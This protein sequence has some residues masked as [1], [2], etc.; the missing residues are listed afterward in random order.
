MPKKRWHFYWHISR[1]SLSMLWLLS[2]VAVILVTI[3]VWRVSTKP[4]DIGFAKNYIESALHD[5]E[6]GNSMRME[7]VV[8]YWPELRGPLYLQLHGGQLVN[9]QGAVIISIDKASISFSRSGLLAGRILPKAIILEQPTLQLIRTKNGE[10]NL[11]L[12]QNAPEEKSQEQFDLTTRI[13]GYIAR[14]GQESAKRSIISRLESFEIKNARFFIDDRIAH[15][16]WSLPDFNVGF[17]STS[18]G[19]KGYVNAKLPDVGLETSEFHIDMNYIWDQKNVE[20]SADF[21]NIDIKATA[22]KIPALGILGQQNIVLNAH[23]ETILDEAFMPADIRLEITSQ[24]GDIMHPDM[25]DDPIPYTDLSLH[26]SYNYGGKA[27]VL[28]DTQITVKDVT[29]FAKADITHTDDRVSG[30]VKIWLADLKQSQIAPLW[31][32]ILRGDNSE[33]WIVKKMSHGMLHDVWLG[34]DLLADKKISEGSKKIYGPRVAPA[35]NVDVENLMAE[36]AFKDMRIDYRA[37]LDAA[38]NVYGSG[39]FDLNKDELTIDIIK[40]KLGVMP[41]SAA[42]LLFDQ[43]AA[44]GK[45]SADVKI[46]LSGDLQDIMRYISKEPINLGDDINMDIAQVRGQADLKIALNFPTQADVKLTEF[47]IGVDGMLRDVLLPDVIGTLDLSGGPL[48]FSV[49]NGLASMKGKAML[50]KRPVDF[51][52]EEFL[53]SKGKPY[54][55]KVTAKITADPNI[56]EM[57]GIDLNDFIEGSL[58]VKVEYVSYRDGS[59]R[60]DVRVDVTPAL[61]FVDPFDFEKPPG[62]KAN[63]TFIAHLQNGNLQKISDLKARGAQF[64]ISKAEIV[65]KT[66]EG[67]TE[68][69]NGRIP[70]F[71]LE[72]TTGKL[73]FVFDDDGAVNI[74]LDAPFLDVQPFMDAE[75]PQGEYQEPPMVISVTAKK[76][77]TAPDEVIEDAKLF[78]DIDGQGRFN[79]MEMDAKVGTGGLYVRFKPDKEGKRTFRLKAD[80]AGA[81]LKAFQVYND[82][83]GGTM[84]I[85]GEPVRGVLDR[86]LRGKAEI[87]NFRVVNAPV[88]TNLLSIM[89]LTGIGEV[90]GGDGLAFDKLE[91]N[92]S[93]L[94]RK[95]GSL[96]ILKEGRT[97]GNSLGLLFDG[98]FDNQKREVNVS[99]TVV[100]MS[101]INEIIGAIP[102]IGDILTGGSG[103]VFAATY[104]VKGP[105]EKPVISVNPLSILTPGILRRILWE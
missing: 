90:L 78:F 54:K 5:E 80:D 98:T 30:P 57:L 4:L 73:D 20:L 46:N 2:M 31:P 65:F 79:Q 104:T 58:P 3:F 75:E 12:G 33:K 66:K 22:E 25:S 34:F 36:F 71:T 40:G 45:G 88:L 60:A 95:G 11:D 105:S 96:L 84:V 48:V 91:A 103:G 39:R 99:G 1:F 26:A 42:T 18:V 37:P 62:E 24:G 29:I 77:R 69:S 23:I 94:Y 101:A 72:D 27:L 19:M 49:K 41:V 8:L 44:V 63:A 82:I 53:N 81:F 92:F 102:I 100:P 7:R 56:R 86:N 21:K 32:K 16:S 85:Y 87:S 55:E 6:T 64:S 43:V 15:Q 93:W 89:S 17:H 59:G 97:S 74:V 61:F 50:A 67:K 83:R 13:F 76:L 35:W 9:Q 14:P 38:V 52:W 51:S 28:R 10:F 70:H 68:L 47:K